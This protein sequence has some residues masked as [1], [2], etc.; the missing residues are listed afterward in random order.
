M[1]L[2]YLENLTWSAISREERFFCQ[3]L[4]QH[5]KGNE[6][7]F[8]QF[9][10]EHG[11]LELED[12]PFWECGYEVCFYRDARKKLSKFDKTTKYSNKRTFDLCLFS[13]SSFV[14]IE[15]KAHQPFKSEQ[16]S[17][18]AHDKDNIAKFL[19]HDNLPVKTVALASSRYFINH[20][21]WGYQDI[22]K[23]FDSKI[24]WL[25]VHS[26][27]RNDRLFLQADETYKS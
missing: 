16:I 21:T 22:L 24:S 18:L 4:Y 7:D 13:E 2:P 20:K 5:I 26:N 12:A 3:A 6:R 25:D 8:V 11:N 10:R 14:I 23:D 9:L 19:M 27:F 1:S 17:Q 15:A